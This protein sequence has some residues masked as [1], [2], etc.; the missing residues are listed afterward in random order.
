MAKENE[1]QQFEEFDYLSDFYLPIKEVE[2]NTPH[3]S[4]Q[5]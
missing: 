4:L 5:D 3:L 1:Q 2:E